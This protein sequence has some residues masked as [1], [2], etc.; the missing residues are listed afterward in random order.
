MRPDELVTQETLEAA[1]A[2]QLRDL[3]ELLEGGPREAMLSVQDVAHELQ[4]STKRVKQML[5]GS[6]IRASKVG[7]LWRVSRRDLD[8]YLEANAN[9]KAG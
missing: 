8:A 3:R 2:R 5:A 1:L 4:V 7:T 9:R 6:E